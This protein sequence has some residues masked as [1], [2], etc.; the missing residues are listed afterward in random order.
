MNEKLDFNVILSAIKK[1]IMF[2]SIFLAIMTLYRI[3]FF[4]KFA[5][6]AELEGLSKYII[7]AF[8]LGVRFDLRI[9]A[10]VNILVVLSIL[11]I[12]ATRKEKVFLVWASVLKY[13]YFVLYSFVFVV[14]FIDFGFYWYFKEHINILVFGLIEDDTMAVVKSGVQNPLFPIALTILVSVFAL[15]FW[16]TSKIS[17]SVAKSVEAP[18]R[19]INI[20]VKIIFVVLLIVV[21]SYFARGSLKMFPL[22]PIDAEICTND[23]INKL[24]LNGVIT[25][26]KATKFYLKNK[27]QKMDLVK[28]CGYENNIEKAFADYL[29][30]DIEKLNK[31]D[32]LSNLMRKTP[33]NQAI[34]QTKPHVVLIAM[35]SFGSNLYKYSTDTFDMLGEFKKHIDSDYFFRK[36]LPSGIITIHAF[37][38]MVLNLPPRPYAPAIT[39]SEYAFIDYPTTSTIPY[40]EQGYEIIFVSG[41]G[42]NW[43]GFNSF[44]PAQGY[45]KLIGG[46]SMAKSSESNEWGVYD[47]YLFNTLYK[48][49]TTNKDK[50][51]FILAKTAGNHPPYSVPDSYKPKPMIMSENFRKVVRGD[52]EFA[53]KR[54]TTYQY[55]NQKLGEFITKVK[56]SDLADSTI[57]AVTGDHNFWDVFDYSADDQFYRYSVP[58]YIYVPDA[59]KPKNVDTEVWGSH[60]DI[61]PTLYNVS[62]SNKQ[63]LAMGRNMLDKNEYHISYNIDGLILTEKGVVKHNFIKNKNTCFTVPQ[64]FNDK[65]IPC[66]EDASF[67]EQVQFY[68]ASI[69]VTDYLIKRTY[70]L[71]KQNEK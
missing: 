46:G 47:E 2:N 66:D 60:L 50:P 9:V 53:M 71:S 44:F 45:D 58:F 54:F 15:T 70:E 59:L 43:R 65:L 6:F 35:E 18:K 16:S 52:E 19:N 39:Q 22:N 23:F 7:E 28:K 38:S 56:N 36:F 42:L 69:A 37:E 67:A 17:K 27:K 30:T 41:S 11:F 49:L 48:E 61:M 64:D 57:I 32:L 13:Y 34:E 26:R 63:Y 5:N 10:Y 29:R 51:K 1:L 24:S 62:L 55:A 12:W 21:E 8:I 3:I 20:W 25:L 4:V 68:K 14:L 31:K 40:K 33:Y